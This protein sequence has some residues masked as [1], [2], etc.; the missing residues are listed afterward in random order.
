MYEAATFELSS[1][2]G[3]AL[4]VLMTI[5]AQ[6]MRLSATAGSAYTLSARGDAS[7]ESD[8]VYQRL[9]RAVRNGLESLG[10]YAVIV[11][12]GTLTQSVDHVTSIAALVFLGGRTLHPIL[13]ALN[14]V[15]FR[16]LAWTAS[17]LSMCVFA[18][19]VAY[20]LYVS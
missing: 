6:A 15:P 9:S 1:L 7:K 10:I 18:G 5:V 19:R 16:S 12:V 11:L 20:N 17:F 4:I 2:L 8:E 3:F 13:Y 14:A